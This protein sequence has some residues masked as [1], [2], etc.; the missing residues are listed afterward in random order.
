M[1]STGRGLT[2]DNDVSD[3]ETADLTTELDRL[4]HRFL[5]FQE[6]AVVAG[7]RMRKDYSL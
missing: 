2:R 4:V 5:A 6:Q 7:P 3:K 1:R